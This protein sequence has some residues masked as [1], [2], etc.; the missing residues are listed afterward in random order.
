MQVNGKLKDKVTCMQVN[1]KLEDKVTELGQ[2]LGFCV[3][4]LYK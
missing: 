2:R 4:E 1:G 3:V